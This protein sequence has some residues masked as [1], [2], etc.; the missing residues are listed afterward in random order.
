MKKYRGYLTA[1]LIS[2]ML[3]FSFSSTS[4]AIDHCAGAKVTTTPN[5]DNPLGV[6]FDV[7]GGSPG[8]VICIG[9][10]P[11]AI[12]WSFSKEL[13]L[14]DYGYGD[15]YYAYTKAGTYEWRAVI[16][17]GHDEGE[18]T[19]CQDCTFSGTV[20]VPSG[21]EPSPTP[22]SSTKGSPTENTNTVNIIG[23][24]PGSNSCPGLPNYAIN[25]AT[26]NLFV[27][28]KVCMYP[29]RGP[30]L[31]MTHAY[32]TGST[33]NSM[34]GR[35]WRFAYEYVIASTASG[36]TLKKGSGQE[37]NFTGSTVTSPSVLTPPTGHYDSLTWMGG[38]W[39]WVEKDTHWTYR[40]D[41]AVINDTA[42][43][44]RFRLTS[45]TDLNNNK[46]TL[47]Y[48]ANNVIERITD[49]TGR[50][51]IFSYDSNNRVTRM[52]AANG[53]F[54]SYQYDS[55]GNLAKSID[56]LGVESTYT[57]DG[58][59]NMTSLST[60]GKTTQFTY[61]TVAD[62]AR[63]AS[64]TD[65]DGNQTNY[66]MSGSTVTQTDP[67]GHQTIYE[68]TGDGFTSSVTDPL[69]NKTSTTYTGGNPT[70]IT[71][72]KG[73]TSYKEYDARGNVTKLT[74]VLGKTSFFTYDKNDNLLSSKNALGQL[75]K[76]TYNTKNKL[77]KTISPL[78]KQT[79]MTYDAKGQMT[80]IIDAAGNKTAF[81][82]NVFGNLIRV[83]DPLGNITK[84]TY[85]TKGLNMTSVTDARGNKTL[86][87]HDANHRLTRVTRPDQTSIKY[88]YDCCSLTSRTDSDGNTTAYERDPLQQIT[89]I[90]DPL[91]NITR[92]AYNQNGDIISATDPLGRTTRSE[93][94]AA[95]RSIAGVNPLNDS[96]GFSH[97]ALGN[98]TALNDERGKNTSMTYNDRSLLT[99]VRDPLNQTTATT[100]YDALGRVSS[101]TNARGDI[102]TYR[103]DAD[104]RLTQR[105]YEVINATTSYA[106]SPNGYLASVSDANGTLSYTRDKAGRVISIAYPDGK[107][108]S[109]TYDRAGNI[110]SLSYPDG[111]KV[112]YSYDKLNRV[113]GVSFNTDNSLTL[114][115][116]A[117]DNLIGETRSNGVESVY[118]YDAARRLTGVSHKKGATV[119]A[120]LS[121]TRNAAGLITEEKGNWPLTFTPQTAA[122][123][124]ASYD[125]A[126]GIV[127]WNTDN[128]SYD[129][130]GNL[131]GISGSRNFTAVYDQQNRLTTITL[132]GSTLNYVYDGLGNRVQGH[133]PEGSDY[134]DYHDAQG[135]NLFRIDSTQVT[136]NYIYAGDRLV[137]SGSSTAGYVFYHYDKIGNTLALTDANG[138]VVA[139]YAYDQYGSFIKT[140]SASTRF[141]YVG[142]Y[143]VAS[144]GGRFFFMKNRFYDATTGR[145]IQRDPI[146]FAGGQTNL[147]AYVGGNPVN[148]IDPSGLAHQPRQEFRGYYEN[149][150]SMK[151]NDPDKGVMFNTLVNGTVYSVDKA[152]N[153][154]PEKLGLLVTFGKGLWYTG[155]AQSPEEA[156]VNI[157]AEGGKAALFLMLDLNPAQAVVLDIYPDV[158]R[159][160]AD[161]LIKLS[162][163]NLR[164]AQEPRWGKISRIDY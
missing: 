94:D 163:C 164:I 132:N 17:F 83:T 104:G 147:Y 42:S 161:A 136:T 155:T 150:S 30:Q 121:Y 122:N 148:K 105:N 124:N 35:S 129:A 88:G 65:A 90:T 135:R 64:V 54:A 69:L 156:L 50:I 86:L 9:Y 47:T 89:S 126:N 76:Y 22:I 133:N 6:H 158:L 8:Q 57:Y 31:A 66:A 116:D 14:N 100:Q 115:Y 103:Y 113:K 63:I 71:D 46:L 1:W 25:T 43:E 149:P 28:D 11:G 82:Y 98:L 33:E 128:Y 5:P 137:A 117:A 49:A 79:L 59:G 27:S 101:V 56:L 58:D 142:A 151:G 32:N 81:A 41:K 38:Y 77:I 108:L 144:I 70:S 160:Y 37:L 2:A 131:I 118:S 93:Y 23:T 125:D 114:T 45:I 61:S 74:D 62:I 21:N 91:G 53:R 84:Y 95:R 67:L 44:T 112:N 48:T 134:E 127:N 97:D 39:L 16:P 12:G 3:V 110:A 4:W 75:W 140:G 34:F 73:K 111:L 99:S 162:K 120:D 18:E 159:L 36:A 102:T 78:N 87:S 92:F 51:T 130:D 68:S 138:I 157:A 153:F 60:G 145:F 20:T 107:T 154:L 29:G 15:T 7:T 106:W 10:P 139:A 109:T 152:T 146:G 143:G 119:I 40:F 55:N 26:L 72:A 52:D 24:G 96:I 85:D 19:Q 80:S 123:I 13:P 141:T